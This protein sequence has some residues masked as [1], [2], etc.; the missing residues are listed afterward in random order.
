MVKPDVFLVWPQHID[1]PFARYML[2]RYRSYFAEVYIAITDHGQMEDYSQFLINNLSPLAKLKRIPKGQGDWRNNAVHVL[3][4]E[5]TGS[6]VLFLEQ[7]FLIRDERFFEVLLNTSDYN[8][9]YYDHAGRVHPA[10]ALVTRDIIDKTGRNFSASP[11]AFDHF[12]LFFSEVLRMANSADLE[13]LGLHDGEDY[14]HLAGLT[15]NYHATPYHKPNQFLTYNHYAQQLP[16]A[17][18]EFKLKME[19]IDKKEMFEESEADEIVHSMF[20]KKEAIA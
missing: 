16:V 12:G 8:F 5:S 2:S 4:S 14:Y 7:D 10:C 13:T 18:N 3:L 19:A 15:E 9:L 11:P 6:W 1:Y 20:P 17:Y